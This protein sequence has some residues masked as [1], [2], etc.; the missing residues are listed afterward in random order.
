MPT[1]VTD[2]SGLDSFLN[3]LGYGIEGPLFAEY[4]PGNNPP[5]EGMGAGNENLSGGTNLSAGIF[6]LAFEIQRNANT[7]I[8]AFSGEN[9]EVDFSDPNN[10]ELFIQVADATIARPR[11]RAAEKAIKRQREDLARRDPS[12]SFR[13]PPQESPNRGDDERTREF[14]RKV[15]ELL[16][17]SPVGVEVLNNQETD[18][19]D[20]LL[21]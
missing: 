8:S 17:N 20:T 9:S 14:E 2:P 21:R 11:D 4:G 6:Q 10:R 3:D 13:Q 16:D 7:L 5:D 1:W 12:P 19:R 15:F 18:M